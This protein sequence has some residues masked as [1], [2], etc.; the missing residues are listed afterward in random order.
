MPNEIRLDWSKRD[1]LQEKLHRDYG[2]Y[3]MLMDIDS[4]CDSEAG[5]KIFIEYDRSGSVAYC[6]FKNDH[7]QIHLWKLSPMIKDATKL[8]IPAYVSVLYRDPSICYY[9]IPLNDICKSIPTMSKPK[10]LSET[11][12]IKF[13][14]Y[15]R[16]IQVDPRTLEGK[17]PIVPADLEL[18]NIQG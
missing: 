13:L 3:I 7:E 2:R 5:L 14:H 10:F 4:M 17:N 6:D 12:Y 16:K 1:S 15:I 9:I 11:N 18:P 8:G